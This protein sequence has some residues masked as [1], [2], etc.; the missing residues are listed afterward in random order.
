MDVDE[1]RSGGLIDIYW[2][3]KVIVMPLILIVTLIVIIYLIGLFYSCPYI[4][5]VNSCFPYN[6]PNWVKLI[7]PVICILVAIILGIV[8]KLTS[9]K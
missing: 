2:I 4:E 1:I 3:F 9:V 8:I 5:D 6:L 7:M